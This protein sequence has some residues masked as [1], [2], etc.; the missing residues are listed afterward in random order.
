MV[1]PGI[2]ALAVGPDLDQVAHP[3]VLAPQ[4]AR[5][6]RGAVGGLVDEVDEQARDR[7]RG[8]D[9]GI[10]RQPASRRLRKRWPSRIART[11]SAT[12]SF[13]SSPSV[14]MV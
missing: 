9:G 3:L 5:A 11:A 4:F 14:R 8:I 6:Q 1:D 2:G 13:S 12:G 10:D 7:E